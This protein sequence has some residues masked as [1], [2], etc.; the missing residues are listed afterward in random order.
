[1]CKISKDTYHVVPSENKRKLE[2]V[3]EVL[4][5]KGMQ[6]VCTE[7][8]STER[9]PYVPTEHLIGEPFMKMYWTQGINLSNV[10]S[11]SIG[12]YYSITIILM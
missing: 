1:M 3:I 5:A 2:H 6:K 11:E 7:S 4:D 9:H 8:D 10:K 12:C